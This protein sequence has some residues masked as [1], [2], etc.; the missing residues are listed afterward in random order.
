[1]LLAAGRGTRLGELGRR[2]PKVLV[3]IAGRPLLAHQ[4]DYLA[5]QGAERVVVNAHHLAEQVLDFVG[6]ARVPFPVDVVV[7]RELLGTAGG[8]RNALPHFQPGRPIIVMNGDTLLSA[9]L[10]G[11]LKSHLRTGAAATICAARL[12]DTTGK[13][14][15][16]LDE[17]MRVTGFE[18]KPAQ[19]RAGLASAG[20]YAI[21]RDLAALI[22]RDV[23]FDFANDLFPMALDLEADLRVHELSG[24]FADVGT[25]E[26]L[27]AARAGVA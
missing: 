5:R 18:E 23:F 6:N 24:D 9:S 3:E 22:P 16:E 1:M 21:E 10:C 12:E 27:A 15:I 26:S 25:P 11:L 2:T 19:P 8:L 17:R 13:G 20:L 14:V 4:F 7:E